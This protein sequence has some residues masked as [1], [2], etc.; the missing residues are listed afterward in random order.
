MK[1]LFSFSIFF[2]SFFFYAQS[3]S[4]NELQMNNHFY[5]NKLIVLSAFIEE[6]NSDSL[7]LNLFYRLPINNFLLKQISDG[8]FQAI[9][10]ITITLSDSD[11]VVRFHR[12]FND[13]ILSTKSKFLPS[14]FAFKEGY[15]NFF[16]PNHKYQLEARVSDLNS[17]K[18]EK[19]SLNFIQVDTVRKTIT[20]I[21]PLSKINEIRYKPSYLFGNF[22]YSPNPKLLLINFLTQNEYLNIT[23]KISKVKSED[24]YNFDFKEINGKVEK[25]NIEDIQITPKYIE[26]NNNPKIT[27]V[28]DDFSQKI[29]YIEFPTNPFVPG[30]YQLELFMG[31]RLIFSTKFKVIWDEQPITLSNLNVALKISE[32]FLTAEEIETIRSANRK[33]QIKTLFEIWQKLDKTTNSDNYPEAM[34]EFYRRADYAYYAFSTFAERNGA[35]TDKGKVYIL[36]GPPDK[37]NEVFKMKKLN[38]IW[39]Y[40]N[41]IK[42]YTFESVES[43]V[44]KLVSIKE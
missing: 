31:N 21:L 29:Y 32:V 4:R 9:A 36:N 19:V 17:K 24:E 41:L 2:V 39:T 7:K 3:Q 44:L 33:N 13:T 20:S 30:N 26:I 5:T 10:A 42:E 28:Q 22:N 38:E 35:L 18:S 12:L 37:I 6:I 27:R 1:K 25:M 16:I 40:S 23:Y 8:N 15:Y 11:G 34:V 14:E 43:G